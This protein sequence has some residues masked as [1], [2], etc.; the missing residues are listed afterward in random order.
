MNHPSLNLELELVVLSRSDYFP[1]HLAETNLLKH[2]PGYKILDW[3][4][5]DQFSPLPSFTN[6]SYPSLTD[7]IYHISHVGPLTSNSSAT[8]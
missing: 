8:I 2:G 4:R 3:Y 6:T 5:L 7:H 1:G